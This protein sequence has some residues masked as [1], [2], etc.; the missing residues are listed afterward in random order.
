MNEGF[1][2]LGFFRN[3]LAFLKI[4]EFKKFKFDH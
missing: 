2:E 3:I 4:I 1:Y